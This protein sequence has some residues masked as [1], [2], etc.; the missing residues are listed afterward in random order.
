VISILAALRKI[1]KGNQSVGPPQ[2]G[3]GRVTEAAKVSV[4][5]SDTHAASI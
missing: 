1:A 5:K 4:E 3:K 2:R